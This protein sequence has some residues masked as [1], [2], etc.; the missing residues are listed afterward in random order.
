[1]KIFSNCKIFL[2]EIFF[3]DSKNF[4]N[5]FLFFANFDDDSLK[6]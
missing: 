5:F 6:N 4:E 1:M 2:T 3:I